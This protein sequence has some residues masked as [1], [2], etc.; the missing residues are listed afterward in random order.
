MNHYFSDANREAVLPMERIFNPL[1][2]GV[3]AKPGFMEQPHY[4][5]VGRSQ[6]EVDTSVVLIAL[7]CV[8]LPYGYLQARRGVMAADPEIKPRALVLGFIVLTALYLYGVSTSIELSENYRYRFNIEPLF[9]VLMVT[10]AT[11]LIRR[12]RAQFARRS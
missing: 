1:L 4:G 2:Y 12:V 3:G 10:A 7:W 6:M 8:L 9:M 5:F 11:D